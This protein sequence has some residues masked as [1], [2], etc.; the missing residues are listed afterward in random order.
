MVAASM[1]AESVVAESMLAESVVAKSMVAESVVAESVSVAGEMVS[2]PVVEIPVYKK[3]EDG[4]GKRRRTEEVHEVE[5]KDEVLI[6]PLG[7][8]A[9]CGGLLRRVGKESVFQDSDLRLVAGGSSTVYELKSVYYV[10]QENATV[11]VQKIAK[12]ISHRL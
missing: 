5:V 6:A 4:K 1:V 3:E 9:E 7:P 10:A 8:R 2:W 11:A 12:P